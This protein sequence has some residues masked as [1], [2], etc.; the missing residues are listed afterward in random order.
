MSWPSSRRCVAKEPG[1]IIAACT[2]TWRAG[3]GKYLLR[4]TL[5]RM[6]IDHPWSEPPAPGATLDVAPGVKWLRMP[7]P[8]Q[9]NHI[10]LWLLEDGDGWTVVDT[11]IAREELKAHWEQ[12]FEAA[13]G[14]KRVTR[15]LVTHFHPDHLGLASWF[16]ERW[17]IELWMT[18][19]EWATARAVHAD[20][21]APDLAQRLRFYRANG[22]DGERLRPLGEPSNFYRQ[23]VPAVPPAFRR[24][25]AGVPVA[26][27][28]RSWVPI[29][30]RGHAPEHACLWDAADGL[31]LCG[32][33][34]LPRI[35]PNVS[36][37]PSEPLQNPLADYLVSLDGF[38]HV[39]AETLVLP[40][41]GL[42]YRG[43]HLRIA[44]LKTHHAERLDRL[45][46]ALD[47]PRAAPECF[48]LLF[49]REIGAS[50]MRL[51]M[52]EALAHLHY[53]E[54]TGRARRERGPDGVWRFARA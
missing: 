34:L 30:G 4:V 17:N 13:L 16:T 33:I 41:H 21:A 38:A 6:A 7:L 12:V 26:I 25:S 46:D 35:S 44:D 29:I 37:W 40:A 50:N 43:I 22:L 42:P 45:A 20:G 8:F 18:Q 28:R 9:L 32:D 14:G 27:G 1:A 2:L 48:A 3:A 51:A 11:G 24:V 15:V 52:G 36:V 53:L 31:L 10:N 5:E 23:H 39:P 19:G 47:P 49:R 54:A